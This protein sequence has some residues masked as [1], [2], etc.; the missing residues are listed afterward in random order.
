MIT[1]DTLREGLQTPGIS[2][3]FNEK[4][5]IATMLHAAGIRRGLVAYPSA[6]SSE[7]EITRKIVEERLF[8]ETYGLGRTVKKDIDLI[9][10]TGA[11]ISLH[12]PFHL[13]GLD[14]IVE[15][16][17]YASRKG[18]LVEVAVVDIVQF[19]ENELVKISKKISDAGAD[20]IQL[21]DTRGSATPRKMKSLISSVIRNLDARVEVHCHND[22]GGA[23]A[24]SVAGAEVGADYVDTTIYGLGERNGIADTVSTISLLRDEGFGID[25]NLKELGKLYEYL[26]ELIFQKIGPTLFVNNFPVFG[27]NT[28]IHTAGTHAAF[29]SVFKGSNFSVNVYTGRSMIRNI[30]DANGIQLEDIKLEKLVNRIKNNAVESGRAV[31]IKEIVKM[32]EEI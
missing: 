26:L 10:S 23:V 20:V 6:H 15:A 25:V 13:D 19:S 21:P 5:K 1:D 3:T 16:V 30:L 8:D 32:S 2:F 31:S 7:V 24:N 17:R 22:H 28:T 12:L 18:K 27:K 29:S 9:E 11:N 14:E 4:L